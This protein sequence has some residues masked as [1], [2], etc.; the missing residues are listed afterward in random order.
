[1]DSKSSNAKCSTPVEIAT[2]IIP[3]IP[4]DIIEEILDRLVTNSDFQSLKSCA[5]VSK[6]WVQSCRQRLFRTVTLT[7]QH[8]DGWLET[9]PVPEESPA[10]HVRVLTVWIERDGHVAKRCFEYTP[11]FSAVEKLWLLGGGGLPSWRG[12]SFW[13]LPQSVTALAIDINV[14]TLVQVRDVI[15]QLPNLDDLSLA[16]SMIVTPV[17]SRELPGIGTALKGRF[18]GQLIL[19]GGS[20]NK[21]LI[22]MLLEIPSGLHFTE[23]QI[24]SRA[25]N[26]L[27]SIVSLTGACR[28]SLVKLSYK[29]IS[30]RKSPSSPSP[31]DSCVRSINAYATSR[32]RCPGCR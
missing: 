17:D 14:I 20:V 12:P 23:V 11:W 15:A 4:L 5:L 19:W 24:H 7:P 30:H 1:M 13:R 6:S 21:D 2:V 26:P 25:R 27:P 22:N 18:G 31:A 3:R 10:H 8:M 29:L 32:C 16:L 28:K 9:F